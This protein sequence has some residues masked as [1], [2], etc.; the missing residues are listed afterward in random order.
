M[1]SGEV[2]DIS[3]E[4]EGDAFWCLHC[5]VA[6]PPIAEHRP[7]YNGTMWRVQLLRRVCAC[8]RA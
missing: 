4:R 7:D 5:P 6:Y 1:G 8:R 3:G 2:L